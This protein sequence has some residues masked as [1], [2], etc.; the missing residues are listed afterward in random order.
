MTPSSCS[1][2]P[3]TEVVPSCRACH[4]RTRE[5]GFGLRGRSGEHV[6]NF[7]QTAFW[8]HT[9]IEQSK[10]AFD[11][12]R[13]ITVRWILPLWDFI[14]LQHIHW[15]ALCFTAPHNPSQ[16]RAHTHTPP[17]IYCR[18]LISPYHT[19][20]LCQG[21]YWDHYGMWIAVRCP[22]PTTSFLLPSQF[23]SMKGCQRFPIYQ[24]SKHA[25][26]QTDTH[27]QKPVLYC[28]SYSPSI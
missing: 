9:H 1:P 22:P 16:P 14:Y 12:G 24:E 13:I 15:V 7:Q 4:W 25:K 21:Y 2:Q 20:F 23:P 17:H 27:I 26:T 6:W 8:T 28:C 18:S 11:S 10:L 5:V 3:T 19:L